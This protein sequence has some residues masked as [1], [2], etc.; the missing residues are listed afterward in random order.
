LSVD[1]LKPIIGNLHPS[2]NFY[3]KQQA[4]YVI[5]QVTTVSSETY[6]NF[7][8]VFEVSDFWENLP[9]I[10]GNNFFSYRS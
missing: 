8:S 1:D 2:E 9:C 10:D 7:G 3:A 5:S 6:V 4:G